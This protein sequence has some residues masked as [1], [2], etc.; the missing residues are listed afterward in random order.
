MKDLYARL[1][2]DKSADRQQLAAIL[3]GRPEWS[4]HAAVLL[5]DEKRALYD[6]THSTLKTIGQLRQRLDLNSGG[7]WFTEHYPDFAAGFRAA[8]APRQSGPEASVA[9]E[10]KPGSDIPQDQAPETPAKSRS[11]RLTPWLLVVIS[12]LLIAL[13]LAAFY[14]AWW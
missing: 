8:P 5:N 6:R 1:K 12:V 11:R 13:L 14:I 10:Q 3:K 7:S 4:E 2:I 9:A